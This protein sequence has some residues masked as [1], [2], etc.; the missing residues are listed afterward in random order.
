MIE[1]WKDKE[2]VDLISVNVVVCMPVTRDYTSC[3]PSEKVT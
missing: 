1:F 3:K 2:V